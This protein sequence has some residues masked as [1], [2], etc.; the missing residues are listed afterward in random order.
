MSTYIENCNTQAFEENFVKDWISLK[1][2]LTKSSDEIK[3]K[4]R[5]IKRKA[6]LMAAASTNST[7]TADDALYD[8]GDILGVGEA[9]KPKV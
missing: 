9:K 1:K 7:A 8:M 5:G 2:R 4:E 3:E 6:M